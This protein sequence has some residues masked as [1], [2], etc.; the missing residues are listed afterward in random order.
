MVIHTLKN[1]WQDEAAFFCLI[2]LIFA[3][4]SANGNTPQ[5]STTRNLNGLQVAILVSGLL[6]VILLVHVA[7]KNR[8]DLLVCP[9][10]WLIFFFGLLRTVLLSLSTLSLSIAI[11]T[12][13]CQLSAESSFAFGSFGQQDPPWKQYRQWKIP[14][15]FDDF[16]S[17]SQHFPAI[18]VHWVPMFR[19]FPVPPAILSPA[20]VD[21]QDLPRPAAEAPWQLN[22]WFLSSI[23]KRE[24]CSSGRTPLRHLFPIQ[25][26]TV[27]RDKPSASW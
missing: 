23:L 19:D 2:C 25:S 4:T 10:D 14:I 15:S 18:N 5:L 16:T 22:N 9:Q 20:H 26:S 13:F 17:I 7:S 1:G 3:G 6:C 8:W 12:A 24:L 11:S 21:V 27:T